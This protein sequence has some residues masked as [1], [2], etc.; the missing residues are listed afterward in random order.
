MELRDWEEL[1][2]KLCKELEEMK[3]TKK[4]DMGDI[5]VIDKITHSIK[6]ISYIMEN[7]DG[8]YSQARYSRRMYNRD[9]NYSQ[10]GNWS[11]EGSYD[12]YGRDNS[13]ARRGMHYVRGHYSRGGD[14]LTERIEEMMDRG[15][16]SVTDK[17]TLQRAM[18]IL[19]K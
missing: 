2:K 1:K 14:E 11:A 5:E 17:S 6:S 8:G 12:N 3:Q 4:F 9:D 16:L 18:D 15:D 10:D 19:R 7:E 13:Y